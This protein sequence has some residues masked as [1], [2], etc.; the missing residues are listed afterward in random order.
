MKELEEYRTHLID[1]LVI[2]A[3]VFREACLAVNEP[4]AA[5]EA[6]GWNVHQ[7]VAHTRDVDRWVYGL[8]AR[9][10]IQEDN[11][12]FSNFN[13]DEYMREHYSASEPLQTMLDDFVKN[14]QLLADRLR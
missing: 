12:E 1:K 4:F 10:T 11:P 2:A 9:R 5:L 14:I 13:G 8:R 7:L 3:E 6:D